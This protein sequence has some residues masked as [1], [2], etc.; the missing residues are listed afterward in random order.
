MIE[1]SDYIPTGNERNST[2]EKERKKMKINDFL[3]KIPHEVIAG[4]EFW[5]G[6]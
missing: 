6:K 5:I 1:L 4:Q 3:Q 2:L